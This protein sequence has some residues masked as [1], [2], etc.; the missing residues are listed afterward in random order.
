MNDD[1]TAAL[2]QLEGLLTVPT[3]GDLETRLR[4]LVASRGFDHFACG[5][6]NLAPKPAEP[7]I[8]MLNAYP[9][10]WQARYDANNYLAYD[11]VI[12]H[13]I[14]QRKAVPIV[15]PEVDALDDPMQRRIF[16][17]A[18]DAGLR[19]GVT[20]ST[21]GQR[22]IGVLSLANDRTPA[23]SRGDILNA[24]G[25]AQLLACYVQ[26]AWDKLADSQGTY[27]TVSLTTRERECLHWAAV[28]KTSWEIAQILKIAE[29][30][31]VYHIGLAVEKLQVTNRRQA[32][33]RAIAL[34]LVSP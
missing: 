2:A 34:G 24:L 17:E 32:V 27:V 29:R 9:A 28:G 4:T 30:T 22:Q 5:V 16:A 18:A 3:L 15:W 6:L 21:Q 1:H 19:S 11:P 7:A 10:E 26:E 12:T 31:V 13:T 14:R 33:A 23:R 25:F 20:V 8:R